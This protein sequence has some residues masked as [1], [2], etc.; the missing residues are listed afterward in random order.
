MIV[1]VVDAFA[2]AVV[3]ND[4]SSLVFFMLLLLYLVVVVAVV[5]SVYSVGVFVVRLG[6]LLLNEC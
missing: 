3:F 2:I 4:L 5:S 1:Y 6:L